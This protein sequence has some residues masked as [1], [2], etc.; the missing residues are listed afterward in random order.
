MSSS[1][2]IST[3]KII[4][5]LPPQPYLGMLP[6]SLVDT[7]AQPKSWGHIE[8]VMKKP[9][10]WC[11]QVHRLLGTCIEIH[12]LFAASG[13]ILV[14]HGLRVNHHDKLCYTSVLVNFGQH[15]ESAN[16]TIHSS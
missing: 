16:L 13:L 1:T 10:R 11:P 9:H 3:A 5:E 14:K 6:I 7:G 2:N 4:A 15:S 8:I 12:L